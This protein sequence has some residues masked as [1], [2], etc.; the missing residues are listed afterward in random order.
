MLE[1]GLGE[2][3]SWARESGAFLDSRI[4]FQYSKQKGY[5]ALIHDFLSG[6]ELIRIPKQMVIGPHLKEQYLPVIN[7][8]RSDSSFSN[9]EMTILLISKL[10]F[11]TSLNDNRFKQYFEILPKDFNIPY[12]WNSNEIDLV[13][14]TDLETIFKK[15]FSKLVT[16][17]YGLMKQLI[18]DSLEEKLKQQ[19]LQDMKFFDDNIAGIP[20]NSYHGEL[21][22]YLNC[23]NKSW[24]SFRNY[25]WSYSILTSRGLPYILLKN[26]I[27][28]NDIQKAILIPIIDL[29]N[30]KNDYKVKWNGL[31]ESKGSH[32]SF[33]CFE[34]GDEFGELY[35]NYGDKSNLELLLGYGF[36][37]ENNKYD[38][39]SISLKLSSQGII[40]EAL[41]HKILMSQ[42]NDDENETIR[43]LRDGIN[44]KIRAD[45]ELP[46]NLVNFFAILMQMG[47]ERDV[48]IS[49]RMQLNG[50]THLKQVIEG[51]ILLLKRNFILGPQV[52]SGV[53]E[54]VKVYR[55]G[56]RKIFQNTLE[57]LLKYEKKLLADNKAHL[58][59]L[60]AILKNDASFKSSL[61]K[62]FKVSSYEEILKK[63]IV[64]DVVLLWIVT[65][66]K[67]KVSLRNSY[68]TNLI[69]KQ[70]DC[71][72]SQIGEV[73]EAIDITDED[74]YEYKPKVLSYISDVLQIWPDMF[75]NEIH[76]IRQY[77]IADTVFDRLSYSRPSNGEL[78]LVQKV[79][80]FA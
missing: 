10:A 41:R 9:N 38:E 18:K 46:S 6:D 49:L 39:T 8:A 20:L 63:Q 64:N 53:H 70:V 32:L 22:E 34:K 33:Q 2:F 11:D 19:I 12:F 36:V 75:K 17:W 57:S 42:D 13:N 15:N 79:E 24:T 25:L 66:S 71:I 45:E 51:K 54:V 65:L 29:L 67:M 80:G 30:H 14:G 69:R 7:Y 58:L 60:K 59:S 73:S 68:F 48:G 28:R 62:I 16:E 77:V 23:E 40:K 78:F 56:Q 35:N 31:K 76:F 61:V 43:Y 26:E 21:Y 74:V 1:R 4:E 27:T 44:F 52:K 3:L 55:N 50:I 5:S 47:F 37:S 72:Y